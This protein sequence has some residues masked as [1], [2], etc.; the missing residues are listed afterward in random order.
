MTR[1]YITSRYDTG[2]NFNCKHALMQA[3]QSFWF[4]SGS[5]AGSHYPY[6]LLW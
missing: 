1:R 4:L 2:S 6:S 5:V 3:A